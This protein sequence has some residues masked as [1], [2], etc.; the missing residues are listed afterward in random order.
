MAHQA[1]DP[2]GPP[3]AE[4]KSDGSIRFQLI[5]VNETAKKGELLERKLKPGQIMRIGRQVVKDGQ[6]VQSPKTS[7][8]DAWFQSKVISRSHAEIWVRE[9]LVNRCCTPVILDAFWKHPFRCM[10]RTLVARRVP[11]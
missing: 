3:A 4:K 7:D 5:P 1:A 2:S 8:V 6:P 9:G 10:S 11:F